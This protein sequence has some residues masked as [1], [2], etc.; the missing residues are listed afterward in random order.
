MLESALIHLKSFFHCGTNGRSP[1]K[2]MLYTSQKK[3]YQ[4]YRSLVAILFISKYTFTKALYLVTKNSHKRPISL[5]INVSHHIMVS[6][7]FLNNNYS[8]VISCNRVES[9]LYRVV[10]IDFFQFLNPFTSW[11][12]AYYYWLCSISRSTSSLECDIR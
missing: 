10:F 4:T 3:K 11:N 12:S 2:L 8:N 6:T 5:I 7:I 1:F 9:S